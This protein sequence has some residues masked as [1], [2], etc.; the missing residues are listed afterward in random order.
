MSVGLTVTGQTFAVN[1]GAFLH[2]TN[3]LNAQHFVLEVDARLRLETGSINCNA[4]TL[5]G[6]YE[7]VAGGGALNVNGPA[8]VLQAHVNLVIPAAFD[9]GVGT[10]VRVMT[11]QSISGGFAPSVAISVQTG[12]ARSATRAI[13][14]TEAALECGAT[15]CFVV[16][17]A[18][19][20][21]V[22]PTNAPSLAVESTHA[23]PTPS[24][25]NLAIGV[26]VGVGA[27]VLALLI[28]GVVLLARRSKN[29][30][31][32]DV[33]RAQPAR[34]HATRAARQSEIFEDSRDSY[35]ETPRAKTPR[36]I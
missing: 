33:E 21:A 18:A 23:A 24:N 20:A 35:S 4:A 10:R 2:V 12:A 22:S 36:R 34:T 1:N 29:H 16:G 6:N 30:A 8:E 26:G 15:E 7:L 9:F 31:S 27:P 3:T 17:R 14:A 5:A 19:A 13:Q 32:S 25:R 28:V 11:F